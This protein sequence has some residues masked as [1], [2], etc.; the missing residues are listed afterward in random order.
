MSE[1]ILTR[2]TRLI[3][4]AEVANEAVHSAGD[5]Y[6]S[7]SVKVEDDNELVASVTFTSTGNKV[8]LQFSCSAKWSGA[9][10]DLEFYVKRGG[11]EIYRTTVILAAN[12]RYS[13][14]FNRSDTPSAGEH[15]FRVYADIP[16]FDGND[17]YV[18]NRSLH[19]HEFKAG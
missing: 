18:Y 11:T 14:A 15:L 12:S 4:T 1:L 2:P 8:Y 17:H 10:P 9:H 3:H 19:I 16:F 6:A 5:Y 7:G 13:V